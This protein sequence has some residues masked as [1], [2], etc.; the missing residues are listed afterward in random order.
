MVWNK[1]CI[2]QLCQRPDGIYEAQVYLRKL[3]MLP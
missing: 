3:E 2:F 1:E